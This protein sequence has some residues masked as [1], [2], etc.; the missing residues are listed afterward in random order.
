MSTSC[1]TPTRPHVTVGE[2]PVT[3]LIGIAADTD[4]PLAGRVN[5]SFDG[6]G[7]FNDLGGRGRLSLNA[8]RWQDA[9]LGNPSAD[10]RLEGRNAVVAVNV[11]SWRSRAMALSASILPARSRFGVNGPPLTSPRSNSGLPSP[12]STP[13]SGSA[14]LGFEVNGTRDHLDELRGLINLDALAVTVSGQAIRLV[15]PGRIEDQRADGT[16][17]KHRPRH[18]TSTLLIDG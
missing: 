12:L 6:Q 18:R 10:I 5:G 14:A 1:A 2:L 7:S 4:V 8:A 15:R 9:D 16:R 13:I 17:R 11:P 3:P